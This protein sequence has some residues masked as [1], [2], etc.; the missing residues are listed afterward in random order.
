MRKLGWLALVTL[1]V[2]CGGKDGGGGDG[3][4]VDED[5]DGY[6]ADHDCDDTNPDVHRGVTE[7]C[8]DGIDNN[9]DGKTDAEDTST[10]GAS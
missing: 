6:A 1:A 10:C 2:A 3:D 7:D 5:D 9:C 8:T 4:A